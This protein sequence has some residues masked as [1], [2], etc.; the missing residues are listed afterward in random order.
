MKL[1]GKELI[2]EDLEN[3]SGGKIDSGLLMDAFN[4]I[5]NCG[6]NGVAKLNLKLELLSMNKNG[7]KNYNSDDIDD[8]FKRHGAN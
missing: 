4:R 5:E 2:D 3:I 1:T 7:D 6:L 8:L